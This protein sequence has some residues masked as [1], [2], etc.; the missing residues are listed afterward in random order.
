MSL[1]DCH[2]CGNKVSDSAAACP[3]CGAALRM[4]NDLAWP[5]FHIAGAALVI[6]VTSTFIAASTPWWSKLLTTGLSGLTVGIAL[7]AIPALVEDRRLRKGLPARKMRSRRYV[8]P[9]GVGR[10]DGA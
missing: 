5:S 8:P 10:G 4:Y 9:R 2:D 3:G 6:A 1:I 7:W